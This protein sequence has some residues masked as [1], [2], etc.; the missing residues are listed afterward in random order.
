MT[1]RS[2]WWSMAICGAALTAALF[3]AGEVVVPTC[4]LGRGAKAREAVLRTDLWTF[5]DVVDQYRADHAE[6]P[7]SLQVLVDKGYLRAIPVDP[8]TK[9]SESWVAIR[10]SANGRTGVAGVHSGSLERGSDGR[11]YSEW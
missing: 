3:V 11:R 9:S 4:T 5:R 6:Y 8:F 10:L 2:L 7:E 1:K